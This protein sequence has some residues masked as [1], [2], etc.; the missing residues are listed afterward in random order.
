M[1]IWQGLLFLGADLGTDPV[2]TF[3]AE[4]LELEAARREQEREQ[5]QHSAEWRFGVDTAR[6][7]AQAV[8]QDLRR[9]A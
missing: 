1:T 8:A 5:Q 7:R 3:A 6:K 2:K 4:E 9:C